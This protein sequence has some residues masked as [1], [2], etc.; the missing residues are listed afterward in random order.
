MLNS[1]TN[2]L[3][4]KLLVQLYS[5]IPEIHARFWPSRLIDVASY[6]PDSR[7]PSGFYLLGLSP[8]TAFKGQPRRPQ[9]LHG[10]LLSCIRNFETDLQSNEKHYNSSE[11]FLSLTSVKRQELPPHISVDMFRWPDNGVDPLVD[12]DEDEEDDDQGNSLEQE[13]ADNWTGYEVTSASK[14]KKEV[15]AAK[16]KTPH[17]AGRLRTS[18]DVFNRLIW[19]PSA[20]KEQYV[21]GYEDRFI[22]IRE[23]ALGN[24]KREVE[25]E[26]FVCILPSTTSSR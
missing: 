4:V 16:G 24:W 12:D 1:A 20:A 26:S 23:T 10:A 5:A 11:T 19:D 17:V 14:R 8:S 2:V 6:D 25:D 15:R 3:Y 22:G 9:E 7:N 13:D 18:A 21:I